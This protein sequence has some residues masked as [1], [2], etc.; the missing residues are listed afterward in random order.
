MQRG[1]FRMDEIGGVG[2]AAAGA[3]VGVATEQHDLAGGRDGGG[4]KSLAGED[5]VGDLV[6]RNLAQRRGVIFATAWVEIGFGDQFGNGAPTIPHDLRRF[7]AG[8]GDQLAVDDEDAIVGTGGEL[9][10]Q[11][12]V[13]FLAGG[14]IGSLDLLAGIEV[15]GDA[16]SLVAVLRFDDDGQADFL[17]DLPGVFGVGNGASGGDGNA[18]GAEQL[19]SQL[20]ILHD[21]FGDGAGPV[22]FGRQNAVLMAALSELDEAAFIEPAGRNAAS[23]GGPDDGTGAGTQP[24]VLVERAQFVDRAF[25]VEFAALHGC[26]EQL[27]SGLQG[28]ASD[29][30]FAILHG[31]LADSGFVRFGDSC[32]F[33]Q[34]PCRIL[35]LQHGCGEQ[36]G[37]RK[38]GRDR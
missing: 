15:D 2:G 22:G 8:G 30:L 21:G 26:R 34:R 5:C 16:A 20:L 3:Q 1:D 6:E 37:E 25:D 32:K 13:F 36:I 14:G 9:F 29:G 23:L 27:Q 24:D 12:V 31:E 38:S 33:D 7:A 19:F 11:D 17:G 10:D 28:H 35:Q 4:G 18:D